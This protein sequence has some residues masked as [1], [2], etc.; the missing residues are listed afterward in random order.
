MKIGFTGT[1]KFLS[2]VRRESLRNYLENLQKTTTLPL[3]FHYGDCIGMDAIAF[4]V[5]RDLGIKTI[6]HPPLGERYRAFTE[7]DVILSE[8][9]YIA[10]NHDI[11]DICDMLIAMPKNPEKEELRSGTWATIRYC[12]KIG[13]TVYII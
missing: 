3:E 6:C 10:R 9:E 7:A 1:R 5:A 11:V 12:T 4:E 13:K 2:V 8:K